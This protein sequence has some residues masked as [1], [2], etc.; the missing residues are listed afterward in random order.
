[1]NYGKCAFACEIHEGP[2]AKKVKYECSYLIIPTM[3]TATAFVW[4]PVRHPDHHHQL[5]NHRISNQPANMTAAAHSP[6]W[7]ANTIWWQFFSKPLQLFNDWWQ[8]I[9]NWNRQTAASQQQTPLKYIYKNRSA[10]GRFCDARAEPFKYYSYLVDVRGRIYYT[11]ERNPNSR[12]WCY[13]PL[14]YINVLYK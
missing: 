11:P 3:T 13:L 9:L 8:T 6:A 10:R 7:H 4:R 12:F 1:M 14:Y 5:I 2:A